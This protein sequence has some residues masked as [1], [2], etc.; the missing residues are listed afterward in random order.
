MSFKNLIFRNLVKNIKNY[1]LY[2]FA[3]IF[4]VALYFAFL[5]LQFDP[6]MDA[7]EG[8]IKGEA[9]MKVAAVMLIAIV[10]VFL[11]YANTLFIKRRGK[12]I[13]LLQLVG[14]SKRKTFWIL[15]SE[16]RRVGKE[17]RSW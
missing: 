10:I 6:S 5:T 8:S 11:I 1:Y 15:R 14:I 3:L 13:G 4:S 7:A 17:C 2:V 16:E 9:A 12:E